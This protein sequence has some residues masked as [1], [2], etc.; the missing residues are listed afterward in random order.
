MINIQNTDDNE[1]F[2]WCLVRYLNRADHHLARITRADEDFARRL[3]FNEIK[4]PVKIRDIH[5]IEEKNSIG[6]S[7]FG[8]E[9]KEK[10]LVYVSKKCREEKHVDLLLKKEGE[11][12]HY[13]FIKDFNT[14]MYHHTLHCGTKHFCRYC[15]YAYR[16]NYK[17]CFKINGKQRIIM[18]KNV[19]ILNSKL[20]KEKQ[21][22]HS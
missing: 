10:H 8:Y 7:V 14:F 17:D 6:I 20:L 18:P 3:D 2:K 13:V 1:Y 15:L 12:K 21:N 16:R 5:K 11:K 9:N 22:H 19:N 4:F